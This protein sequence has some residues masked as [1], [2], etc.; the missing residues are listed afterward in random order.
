MRSSWALPQL[1]E[2]F[3]ASSGISSHSNYSSVQVLEGKALSFGLNGAFEPQMGGHRQLQASVSYQMGYL[4]FDLRGAW[5]STHY[6]VLR[7]VP[8]YSQAVGTGLTA[9]SSI[10]SD[11]EMNR[12]RAEGDPWNY[13]LVEPGVSVSG[14]WF[15]SWLPRFGQRARFGVAWASLSDQV[16]QLE[17]NGVLISSSAEFTYAPER[18]RYLE[19]VLGFHFRSGDVLNQANS[20]ASNQMRRLPIHWKELSAGVTFWF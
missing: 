2:E 3:E 11:S 4:G 19:L 17:F 6:G 1:P 7:V 12:I 20:D 14:R 9:P 15:P 18:W 5:G 16:N 10:E 13:H 8:D